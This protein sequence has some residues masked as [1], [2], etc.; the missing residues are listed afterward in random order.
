MRKRSRS[1]K[2]SFIINTGSNSKNNSN[3]SNSNNMRRDNN[4]LSNTLF[5]LN[6]KPFQVKR[7]WLSTLHSR[8]RR[9]SSSTQSN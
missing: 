6:K 5:T 8:S 2:K 1:S 4:T 7:I 9:D 3:N